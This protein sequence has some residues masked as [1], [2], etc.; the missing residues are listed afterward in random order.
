MI[1]EGGGQRGIFTSG[2]LDYLMEKKVQVP[3]VLGVSAGAC[4]AVDYVSNQ[5]LRTKECMLDAQLD[6]E[7][8]GIRTMVETKH[9]MN[10]DLIFDEFPNHLYPFDY[11]AY[12]KSPTRCL[13]VTTNCLNGK[14]EYL[15]EYRSREKMM[16]IC[17]ASSSLPFGAPMVKIDGVPMLDGGIADSIPV[18]KAIA[19]GFDHNI[20][21][22]TR[23]KG[24]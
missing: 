17:R 23:H 4:N 14:A 1:L 6:N 18:R 12:V 9:F 19:D 11:E 16:Q 15:E 7:L 20:V 10:M 2:V 8:Y 5:I 3:Y 24:Y 22:L 13:L 21:I